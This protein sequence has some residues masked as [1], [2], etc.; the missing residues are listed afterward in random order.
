MSKVYVIMI[1]RGWAGCDWDDWDA[2]YVI[3]EDRFFMSSSAAKKYADAKIPKEKWGNRDWYV[4][5]L[6]LSQRF[7]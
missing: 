3:F 5:E 7:E 1:Q 6:K 4:Q 2:S